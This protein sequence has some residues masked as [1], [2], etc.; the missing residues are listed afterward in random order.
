MKKKKKVNSTSSLAFQVDTM[1]L[2]LPSVFRLFQK[3]K[4][5]F[6]G[7]NQA[8]TGQYNFVALHHNVGI[9]AVHF[10]AQVLTDRIKQN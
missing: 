9:F 7:N 1:R 4:C 10:L 3:K 8:I 2:R 5:W 6:L